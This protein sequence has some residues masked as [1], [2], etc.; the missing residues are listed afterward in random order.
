MQ[1]IA[2]FP[3][4][5][6]PEPPS[7][8]DGIDPK[9]VHMTSNL[10][11]AITDSWHAAWDKGDVSVFDQLTA[12]N[13][14]RRS[15]R[16][17]TTT[18]LDAIKTD[19]LAIRAA[20]PDLSTTVDH[21]VVDGDERDC[22]VAVYWHSTG[23]FTEPL[24]DVP[25]TGAEVVTTGSNLLTFDAGKI[26]YEE[27]TW[28]ASALLADLGLKS[29]GSA[30][31]QDV[32]SISDNLDGEPTKE[33]LKAFNRQFITGVTV[34]T[35]MDTDGKP[36]GLAVNSYNSV[37]LEPPLVM[38]CVQKTSSTYPSLFASSHMGI[39][40]L[41]CNQ[42][43]TLRTFASKN[44]DKFAELD[45]HQGPHGSPL[46]DGSSAA[47]EVEIKERFQ[48]LT[49]TIFVGRVRTS[50]STDNDPIIYKAGQF[51]ESHDL[52]PLT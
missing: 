6:S 35:T 24:G 14:Q 25:P 4:L 1:Q 36:R 13:Y 45:W 31:D 41:G 29:L 7:T 38:V 9:E 5:S 42:R 8:T 40:I 43:D 23:T 37:S 48:A 19:I 3:P 18:G 44:A 47:I 17:A 26:V 16:S 30:F 21:I 20:F 12:T 10:K 34:V 11:K 27:A 32:D 46:L 49:H 2:S 33:A 22:K 15:A 51:F 39:N 50:E 52:T 28:D